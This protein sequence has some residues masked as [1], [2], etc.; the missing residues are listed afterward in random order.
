MSTPAGIV[1]GT[2]FYRESPKMSAPV[3][4]FEFTWEAHKT[5]QFKT[6]HNN[7]SV[8]VGPSGRYPAQWRHLP[9]EPHSGPEVPN[10]YEGVGSE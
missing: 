10:K 4:A 9:R 6:Y 1:N 5:F 7:C 2:A 8:L 3:P